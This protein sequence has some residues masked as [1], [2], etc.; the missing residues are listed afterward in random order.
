[1]MMV[2]IILTMFASGGYLWRMNHMGFV[3]TET[4]SS[5]DFPVY[6]PT[7]IPKGF[8]LKPGSVSSTRLVLTYVLLSPSGA[9]VS[10]S[11]QAKPSTF[12]FSDFYFNQ[13]TDPKE[14][15]TSIGKTT[16]GDSDHGLI[17][18]TE[19]DKTW[20]IMHADSQVG[21]RD[22]ETIFRAMQIVP[23]K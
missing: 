21:A 17:V 10:I 3:P 16:Y 15:I 4:A 9:M 7:K 8:T 14:I 12:N 11:E 18:S 23:V 13:L 5:L 2:V 6:S 22:I 19:A 20:I 1:M